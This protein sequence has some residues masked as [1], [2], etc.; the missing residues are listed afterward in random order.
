[1]HRPGVHP[2]ADLFG[3]GAS[4]HS[5]ASLKEFTGAQ[6]DTP[7]RADNFLQTFSRCCCGIT[8]CSHPEQIILPHSA[9]FCDVFAVHDL[10][11][12]QIRGNAGWPGRL[13][14]R[15]HH[16]GARVCDSL[17]KRAAASV[18]RVAPAP[19]SLCGPLH[20]SFRVPARRRAHLWLCAAVSQQVGACLGGASV[21][22]VICALQYSTSCYSSA[23]VSGTLM[24][25]Y[26]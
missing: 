10:P 3:A 5:T 2:A 12:L 6:Q 16:Q 20:T 9:R 21:V 24:N 15:A 23:L 25:F 11:V 19:A 17:H 1:M 13:H 18:A 26:V 14:R 7:E 4:A 22:K 8:R